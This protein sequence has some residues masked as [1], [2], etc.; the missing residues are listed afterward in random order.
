MSELATN[1]RP[2]TRAE[3]NAYEWHEVNTYGSPEA[4]FVVG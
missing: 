1:R 2:L 3:W 4:L